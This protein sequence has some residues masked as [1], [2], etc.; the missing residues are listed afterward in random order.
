MLDLVLLAPSFLI[1]P[2]RL[3]PP[4]LEDAG[5]YCLDMRT[6]A[7]PVT[8]QNITNSLHPPHPHLVLSLSLLLDLDVIS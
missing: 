1:P 8:I 7:E 6:E 2:S 3:F 4:L 5:L